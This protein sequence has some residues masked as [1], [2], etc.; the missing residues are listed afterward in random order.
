MSKTILLTGATGKQGR[1]LITTLLSSPRASDF[2][3]LALTRNTTSPSASALASKSPSIRLIQGNLNDPHAIFAS[4]LA[5]TNS[6]PIW[7][8]YSVQ[9]AVQDGATEASE[10]KQGKELIDLS[11]SHGVKH[12]VYSS[13]ERGGAAGKPGDKPTYVPHFRSKANIEEHLLKESE[14]GKKMSYTIIRPVFFVDQFVPG[15][16][17]KVLATMVKVSVKPSKPLQYVAVSDIGHFAAQGFLQSDDPAYKNQAINL[18]GDELTFEQLSEV[19]EKKMGYPVPT[20]FG[21]IAR[22]VKWMVTELNVMFKWFDE[23]G[24]GADIPA[25]KRMHPGLKSFGDWLE[26]E[27]AFVKK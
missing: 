10:T 19:F 6:A 25:L 15:F 8:V 3:I 23:E 12:F 18:A 24:F 13:V 22:F 11:L 21:F 20:T 5:A 14:E 26:T 9:Q 7:G 4:A 27:S 17:G 2:T 16:M 1:A